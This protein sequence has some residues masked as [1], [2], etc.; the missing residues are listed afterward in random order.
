M[1]LLYHLGIYLYRLLLFVLSVFGHRKARLWINGR[2]GWKKRL[3]EKFQNI[4]SCIWFH[5]ASVGE[6]ELSIPLMESLNQKYPHKKILVTFFSPSGYEVKKND[7]LPFHIDYLPIDSASNASFFIETV[8]PET[9]LFAKYDYWHYYL[10]V[11][12]SKKIPTYVFSAT[13]RSSQVFFKPYGNWY[14]QMLKRFTHL[15]V[16]NET[17]SQL[18]HAA[19]I[20]Q[21]S[22]T[23][24]NRYDRVLSTARKN[25][26]FHFIEKF[27]ANHQLMIAGSTWPEDENI[28]VSLINT[29]TSLKYIIAP[30]EIE[31]SHL[32]QLEASL[33]VRNIRYSVIDERTDL[34][35]I[36]VVIIDNIGM[37]SSLYKYGN[38]AYV[39]GAFKQ[40]L[41]NILEPLSFG[42]PVIF[43]PHYSK[44]PEAFDFISI[45]G[46]YSIQD[47]EELQQKVTVLLTPDQQENIKTLN[48]LEIAKHIG[49]TEKIMNYITWGN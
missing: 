30:H 3:H 5:C 8:K 37:L 43:G 35:S 33:T 20:D 11:L 40:G 34:E 6:Y 4:P 1:S 28:L 42:L 21:V 22:V 36:S 41:H 27:K 7:V 15:F 26:R 2:K 47:A 31:A 17:S 19:G 23:G 24:D 9:V 13:F 39:G 18:L 14:K 44:F 46:A 45:G 16:V 48:T 38:I 25:L 32:Q 49:A 12:E 10:K 29:N